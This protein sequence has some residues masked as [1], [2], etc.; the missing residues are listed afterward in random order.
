M[1]IDKGY[2]SGTRK[3]PS[4]RA[5]S[6]AL[7]KQ[8]IQRVAAKLAKA[9]KPLTSAQATALGIAGTLSVGAGMLIGGGLNAGRV[10]GGGGGR[11]GAKTK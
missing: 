11:D 4:A 5:Q 6:A 8:N 1:A 3:V 7:R 9:G 10:G 2:G